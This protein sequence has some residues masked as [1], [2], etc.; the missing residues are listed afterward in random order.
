MI[1]EFFYNMFQSLN[2]PLGDYFDLLG[3]KIST[4]NIIALIFA[5]LMTITIINIFRFF[6]HLI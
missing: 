5:I 4:N 2:F 1:S 3:W 6:K